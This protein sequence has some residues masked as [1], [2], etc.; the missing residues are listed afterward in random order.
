MSA[1]GGLVAKFSN[2]SIRGAGAGYKDNSR[3]SG[4]V[5]KD[6]ERAVRSGRL[7]RFK[8]ARKIWY[9]SLESM[10]R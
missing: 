5:I 9:R 1:S 4:R 2:D 8:V 6:L 3:L 7:T 10:K